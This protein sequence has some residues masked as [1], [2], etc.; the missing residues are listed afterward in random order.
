MAKKGKDGRITKSFTFSGKRYFIHGRSVQEVDQK[1]F[2]R[3][4]TLQENKILHDNPTLDKYFE[5]WIKNK[6]GSVKLATLPVLESKYRSCADVLVGDKRFGNY[7]IREVKTEDIR[8]LQK[9]LNDNNMTSTTNGKVALVKQ[10]FQDAIIERYTD[11]NPCLGVKNLKRT[12][13]ACRDTSHRCL[14]DEE[15]KKFFDAFKSSSYYGVCKFLLLSG[16]RVG[17]AGGLLYSDIS[18]EYISI[19]RTLTKDENNAY[20][21]GDSTK[22]TSG[23]RKIPLNADLLKVLQTQKQINRILY[24]DSITSINQ[25]VFRAPLGGLLNASS[26][27]S[28]IYRTCDK[29]GIER[30]SVHGLRAT[31]AS[32][33]LRSGMQ[34]KVLQEILGHADFNMTVNLYSH[35]I[36][37]EKVTQMNAIKIAL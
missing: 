1:K 24:D 10:L 8:I 26:I 32:N 18:D 17:E 20:I 23:K 30:F 22:T 21:V 28:A 6:K 9:K 16:C 29:I 34:P 13:R 2:E 27:D 36:D 14:S 35:G 3:L 37:S 15:I 19:Q 33:C 5:S 25:R 7:Q 31:F 12:E 4:K 11:F